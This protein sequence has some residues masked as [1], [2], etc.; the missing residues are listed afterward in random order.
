MYRV[1]DEPS[2][3]EYDTEEEYDAALASYDAAMMQEEDEAVERRC[4]REQN[5]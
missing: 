2:R 1:C 4:E 5:I 3:W